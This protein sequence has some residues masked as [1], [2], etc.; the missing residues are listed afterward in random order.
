MELFYTNG[1]IIIIFYLGCDR[2]SPWTSTSVVWQSCNDG[3]V[4]SFVAEWG[5]HNMGTYFLHWVAIYPNWAVFQN[6]KIGLPS[7]FFSSFFFEKKIGLLKIIFW[8]W[9]NFITKLKKTC[10]SLLHHLFC[11]LSWS[12]FTHLLI[13]L[14]PSHIKSWLAV[15]KYMLTYVYLID[16]YSSFM[17]L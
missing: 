7:S 5:V 4:D 13:T 11:S 12:L 16:N 9:A 2:R 15:K 14:F 17:A 3:M 6:F 1:L 10:S 8:T